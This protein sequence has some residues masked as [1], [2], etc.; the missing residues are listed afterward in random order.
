MSKYEC[1][2]WQTAMLACC[3]AWQCCI[4]LVVRF[5]PCYCLYGGCNVFVSVWGCAKWAC[6]RAYRMVEACKRFDR[7]A[8]LCAKRSRWIL[9]RDTDGLVDAKSYSYSSIR[10]LRFA[11][12][13]WLSVGG[14]GSSLARQG[15]VIN[16]SHKLVSILED[17]SGVS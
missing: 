3:F 9:E 4:P 11:L 8:E 6:S 12:V 10:C 15:S 16:S 17:A 5:F 1:G 7:L 2:A 14:T 13:V